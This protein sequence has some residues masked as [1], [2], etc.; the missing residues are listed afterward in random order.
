MILL[1]LFVGGVWFYRKRKKL[2]SIPFLVEQIEL[3]YNFT[4]QRIDKSHLSKYLD[5]ERHFL[6]TA[7]SNI[8]RL[9]ERLRHKEKELRQV[10]VDWGMYLESMREM[11]SAREL[12]DVASSNEDADSEHKRFE[13][14]R[15]K[16]D[17]IEK[18][19]ATLL[20]KDYTDPKGKL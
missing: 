8:T 12:L 19:F 10:V 4:L 6:V 1:I 16:Q 15:T 11:I 7:H 14:N 2:T 20:G 17:E 5:L 13:L 18:R 9:F 3:H